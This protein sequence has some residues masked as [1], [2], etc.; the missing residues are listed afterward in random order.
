M[1]K[2]RVKE[3]RESMHLSQ[4]K[5]GEFT[6]ISQQVISKIER[7]DSRLTKDNMII[8]ADF[9]E[10]ST[11]YLLGRSNCKRSIE[12]EMEMLNKFRKYDDIVQMYV[13]LGEKGRQLLR[14]I[15]DMLIELGID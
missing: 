7:S 13:M 14:H 11:D 5:L 4:E 10:V 9:F 6:N 2:N 8:L 15:A 12:Q 3:L 1:S